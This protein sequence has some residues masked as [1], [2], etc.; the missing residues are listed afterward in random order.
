MANSARVIA[1]L[2]VVLVLLPRIALGDFLSPLLSPSLMMCAKK[3]NVEKELASHLVIALSSMNVNAISGGVGLV[4]S[5]LTLMII[6]SFFLAWF[7]I[8]PLVTPAQKPPHPSKR[9]HAKLMNPSLIPATGLT[10][11]V[12]SATRHRFSHTL[13]CVWRVIIIFSMLLPSHV[14]KNVQ[15]GWIVRTLEF[16][17]QT[18][19]LLPLK[20]WLMKGRAQLLQF[21]KEFRCG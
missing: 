3:W 6:S 17:F 5:L 13:V 2:A 20:Q 16:H 11:E 15:L 18:N 9:K 10:V 21:Y 19:L 4:L 7:P 8:V 12:V 14:L 1:F